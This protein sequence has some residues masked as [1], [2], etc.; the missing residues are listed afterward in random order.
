VSI[1]LNIPPDQLTLLGE[2]CYLHI[3]FR[4]QNFIIMSVTF[5]GRKEE[6]AILNDAFQSNRPEMVAVFGRRRVGKTFLIKQ[7]YQ[8]HLAFELTGLQNASNEEQLQHFCKQLEK[9]S[10]NPIP[11]KTPDN[12]LQAFFML[13][14]F[15]DHKPGRKKRVV[16][17]DEV[18]WLA[19]NKS[20]F[21][22][23]LG[24][25]WNS[26]AE[27][28]NI[29][30]VICGSAASW[31]I[32]K[33][34]RDRGGLHNRITKR[35]FLEP[36]TLSETEAYLQSRQVYYDRYQVLQVY[37]AMGGIPHYLNEIKPGKSA[38]QNINNA[39]FSKKS[40]LRNEFSNLYAALFANADN[41]IAAIR[42]LA[43][44]KQGLSRPAIVQNAGLSEGGNTSQMLEELEQSGFITSYFPFGKRKKDMLYRL[45]DEYSLFYLRFIERNKDSGNN[46]WNQLSQTPTAKVWAGYAY[47]N[48]CLKHLENIKKALGISGV[49]TEASAFFQ[50]GSA[51]EKGAQIDLVLDRADQTI[52]LFEIKFY[53][54]GFKMSETDAKA[55]RNQMWIFREKT[56]TKKRLMVVLL[57]TFGMA[58][59]QHSLGL[60][61]QVLTMD[62]LFL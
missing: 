62:D 4:R 33:I 61:E 26:W 18:P 1:Y 47:E 8:K 24:W 15:L 25:F 29:V 38:T 17:F 3:G 10:Q 12:W 19:G 5:I 46:T 13:A 40:L 2:I 7:T 32:Q 49:Y 27:M 50:K 34:V 30:V 42:A 58:H 31:M 35:V 6:Q 37:M 57:C 54:T 22:T 51:E 43:K 56:K 20:S 16:F 48:A 45:T 11:V 14:K 41:H 59:N 44:S 9:F 28:R 21:I 39:C 36:F 52:N 23:G 53:N 60:V 55:L